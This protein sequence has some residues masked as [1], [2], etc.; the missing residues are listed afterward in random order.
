MSSRAGSTRAARP[1][2]STAPP[3]M[4][5]AAASP[6]TSERS[7]ACR[8]SPSSRQ[9]ARSCTSWEA[10]LRPITCTASSTAFGAG[11]TASSTTASTC[12]R[13]RS[14]RPHRRRHSAF[15][16]A[17]TPARSTWTGELDEAA[18]RTAERRAN[19]VVWEAR[20]VSARSLTRAR[21]RS[22]RGPCARGSGRLRAGRRGAGLRSPGV[23]RH[24][25]AQ[26]GRGRRGV[27]RS[28]ASATRA[29]RASVSCA[30]SAPSRR[31]ATRAPALERLGALLSAPLEELPAAVERALQQSE[32]LR[33]RAAR[34]RRARRRGRGAPAARRQRGAAGRCGGDASTAGR[35]RICAAWPCGWWRSRRASP[36]SAS[37]GEKAQLVLRPVRGPGPRRAGTA[38]RGCRAAGR[39]RRRQGQPGAGRRRARRAPGRGS[40][41]GGRSG[42]QRE[43]RIRMSAPPYLIVG[44]AVVCVSVGSILVRLAQAPALAV[45]FHRVFLASLLLAPFAGPRALSGWRGAAAPHPA[46]ARRGPVRRWR[47]ISAPGS[48]ASPT[49][50]SRPPSCSSTPR[51]CSRSRSPGSS[52]AS[53][54]PP[55]VLLAIAL[56]L[57]GAR[58]DRDRRLVVRRARSPARRR[59]GAR[60]RR[61]AG[62]STTWSGAAC[63]RRCRSTP[64]SSGSGAPPRRCWALPRSRPALRSSA[65]RRGPGPR[66]WRWPWCPRWP[67]TAW[68]T[69]R[70]GC[71]RRPTVGLFLLGEPVGATLLAL[72]LFGETPGGWTLAGGAV[73]LA[74]L[75]LVATGSRT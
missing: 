29:A 15:T 32:Q 34:P 63:A 73:I 51:R 48:P 55:R 43:R 39:P 8:S 58:P 6:G 37:R 3:S 49:R 2:C 30:G 72:A 35:R 54:S 64:T 19:E 16:S 46:G 25:S 26:H 61:G 1:S 60:W 13:A 44:L 50:R 22:T 45:S 40:G 10:R 7:R 69:C 68:S 67:A 14:W 66:S 71:C 62:R 31:S 28:A 56:A 42:A 4:P 11:T 57:A 53:G 27:A 41:Q 18:R 47:S 33:R 21:G 5:R 52:C 38:S 23:R 12:S 17:A 75:A 36:C 24:A 20:P 70:C 74:S 59:A 65:T 9:R